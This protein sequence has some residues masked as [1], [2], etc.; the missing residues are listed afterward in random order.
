M[1]QLRKSLFE[2]E[3]F[4]ASLLTSEDGGALQALLEQSSDYFELVLGLPPGPGAAQSLYAGLPEGKSYE[5]KFVIGVFESSGELIG[6]LDVIRDYKET[7][8]WTLGLL[9]IHPDR[10]N[11]GLGE[12]VYRAFEQ[13]AAKFGA[14]RIRLGVVEQN[15]GACRF[16]KRMEFEVVERL[17]KKKHGN[18]ESHVIIMW[19]SL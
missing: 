4:I 19:R 18:K 14:N 9:L 8:E 10:R 2:A 11:K 15:E 12:S 1:A 17:P 6:V 13:W 3:D 16:W 7:G 5:D